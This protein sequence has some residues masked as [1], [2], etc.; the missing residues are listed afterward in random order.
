MRDAL[1]LLSWI[2]ASRL[3][4]A[5]CSLAMCMATES[6]LVGCS[7]LFSALHG[8]VFGGTLCIYTLP[9]L[10]RTMIL[11]KTRRFLYPAQLTRILFLCLGSVFVLCTAYLLPAQILLLATLV[12]VA[13]LL[14]TIPILPSG[15]R[16][17]DIG[18][19]KFWTLVYIWVVT[20]VLFPA[21]LVGTPLAH[22]SFVTL[23][24]LLL[25][26]ALCL[27]FDIRDTAKDLLKGI[28]TFPVVFGP[29]GAR[30]AMVVCYLTLMVLLS[31]KFKE[32]FR[33]LACVTTLATL[34]L[35]ILLYKPRKRQLLYHLL[36]VDG[37]MMVYALVVIYCSKAT[38]T[39]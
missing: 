13:A 7:E 2:A 19:I 10:W 1:A 39:L 36:C 17:S 29:F 12:C 20:T 27:R 31:Y 32:D 5:F 11:S 14:Y 25:I 9:Y 24:H 37:L 35:M 28:A 30:L 16:L 34:G 23:C 6:L 33:S 22:A 4:I 26:L 18:S 15:F 3:F 8:F 38:I 21:L